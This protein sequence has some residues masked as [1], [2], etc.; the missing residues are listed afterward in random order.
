MARNK[1]YFYAQQDLDLQ[2]IS[3]VKLQIRWSY[4]FST[5]GS[6]YLGDKNYATEIGWV[7]QVMSVHFLQN[8]QT[9]CQIVHLY[10]ICPTLIKVF[11]WFFLCICGNMCTQG[12]ALGFKHMHTS[13]PSASSSF[14]LSSTV[15]SS[16]SEVK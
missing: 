1:K 6:F 15:H 5:D 9:W 14:K 16:S 10:F 13:S 4:F 7:F 12:Q 2:S 3:M 8:E 11:L